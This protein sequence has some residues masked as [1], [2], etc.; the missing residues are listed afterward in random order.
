MLIGW[1]QYL[2]YCHSCD[3]SLLYTYIEVVKEC[4][5]FC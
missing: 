1:H 2:T 4:G 3:V 5:M